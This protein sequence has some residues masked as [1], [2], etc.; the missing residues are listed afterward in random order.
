MFE[1]FKKKYASQ[2]VDI[3]KLV[4][5]RTKKLSLEEASFLERR[6]TEEEVWF[7]VKECGNN[8]SPGPDGFTI[9]FLKSFWD[10]IKGDLMAVMEWF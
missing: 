6:M 9:G 7:A 10:I 3:P 8:K 4:L 1:F 2:G 5:D